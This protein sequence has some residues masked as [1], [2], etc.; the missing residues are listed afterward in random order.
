MKLEYI[1]NIKM[2]YLILF[3]QYVIDRIGNLYRNIFDF[4]KWIFL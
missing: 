3:D 1:K 4:Y 2:D